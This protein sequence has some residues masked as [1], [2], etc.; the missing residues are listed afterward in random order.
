MIDMQIRAV[1][2]IAS[3]LTIAQMQNTISW[4]ELA[5]RAQPA[6]QPELSKLIK[7]AQIQIQVMQCLILK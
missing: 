3:S 6:A 5:C 7:M 1:R 4:I 2:M